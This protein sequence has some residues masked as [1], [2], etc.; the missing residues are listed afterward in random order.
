M[1]EGEAEGW[2][3]VLPEESVIQL[4]AKSG[5]EAAAGIGAELML[6]PQLPEAYGF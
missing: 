1:S 3:P 6:Q 5:Q 2:A 4:L